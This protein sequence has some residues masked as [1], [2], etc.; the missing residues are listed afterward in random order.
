MALVYQFNRMAIQDLRRRL[1]ARL[2]ALP[3]LKNK[4]TALR[5]AVQE[6]HLRLQ[7]AQR[8]YD[9]RLGRVREDLTLWAEFPAYIFVIERLVSRP[10]KVTGVV[11]PEFV[12]VVWNT[13]EFSKFNKPA[14]VT[15]GIRVLQDLAADQA[16]IAIT[17]QAL[18]ILEQAR[19]RTTQKVN[20]YEKVQIPA[21][22]EAILRVKRH[23]E[24]VDNLT[25]AAQ[26]LT[27]QRLSETEAALLD[28]R[29]EP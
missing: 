16:R 25:K 8:T 3:T 18:E 12:E 11:Y 15:T 24:D 5:A 13:R 1:K 2:T 17:G 28:G 7:E 21:Y 27:K 9:E 29:S 22:S 19:K 14:W 26:K 23:L 4:E 10:V 20:L 6:H